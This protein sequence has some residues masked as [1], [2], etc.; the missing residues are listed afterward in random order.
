MATVVK[1]IAKYIQNNSETLEATALKDLCH[2]LESGAAFE[3][4][5]L[6][7]LKPKAFALA[8]GMLEEWRFDRHLI[9]RRLQKYLS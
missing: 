6:Y 8:L 3:L 9:E 5:R 4:A 1:A 7:D 2:S